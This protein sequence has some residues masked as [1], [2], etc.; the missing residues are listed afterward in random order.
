MNEEQDIVDF[1]K[2]VSPGNSLRVVINDL[3][4]A[5][6]GALIVF[7]SK[8]L[9]EQNIIE[10]GFKVNCRFTPQKLFELCK[11]DGAI[12]I[13]PDLRR[14]LYANATLSPDK[15]IATHETGTRHKSAERTAKQA[16]TFVIAVSERKNKTSL[17]FSEKKYILRDSEE[18]LREISSNIQVLEK[19]REI[20][21]EL[22][23]KLNILEA[24]ELVSVGDVCKVLQRAEMILKISESIKRH[25]IELGNEAAI[26]N[27]RHKELLKNVSSREEAIIGDY[28]L[29]P[30]KKAKTIL[31]CMTFEGLLDLEAISS[32]IFEKNSE[33]IIIPK[34]KR[35]L[36]KLNLTE[37]ERQN[38]LEKFSNLNEII[39]SEVESF[40]EILKL[41]AEKT[42]EDISH[43]REQIFAG[44]TT[45]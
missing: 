3:L 28:S 1:I 35:F 45:Y 18:L 30:I 32:L 36:S 41:K 7:N 42:K 40:A 39:N 44:K 25:F 5:K 23:S 31:S 9:E 8:E 6:L 24:S 10:G 19:Q 11:M 21:N 12:I 17:F 4:R 29:K 43:L 22:L 20:F 14:I 34:G 15:A 2:K 38:L 37:K 27:T 13:S 33:E 16:K 26:M